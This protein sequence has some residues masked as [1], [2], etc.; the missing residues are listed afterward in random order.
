MRVTY[1]QN[2]GDSCR[3]ITEAR[4]RGLIHRR[5]VLERLIL[6]GARGAAIRHQAQVLRPLYSR[7]LASGRCGDWFRAE[8]LPATPRAIL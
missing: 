8:Q 4:R 7:L 6:R 2:R 3:G 1:R 5:K